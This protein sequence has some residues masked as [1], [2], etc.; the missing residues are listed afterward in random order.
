MALKGLLEPGVVLEPARDLPPERAGVA[1]ALVPGDGARQHRRQPVM[2]GFAGLD[3]QAPVV[4]GLEIAG[5]GRDRDTGEEPDIDA[6]CQ[7]C[8]RQDPPRC[9]LLARDQVPGKGFPRVAA[10]VPQPP[11]L[12]AMVG[13]IQPFEPVQEQLERSGPAAGQ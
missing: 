2:A 4:Q 10:A 6:R 8:D 7:R 13:G 12:P 1:G 3:E 5:G 11:E 9:G